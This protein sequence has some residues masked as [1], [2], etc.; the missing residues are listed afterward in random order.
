[1][2]PQAVQLHGKGGFGC[3]SLGQCVGRVGTG[4]IYQVELKG[5]GRKIL[6]A[7]AI[8]EQG[9]VGGLIAHHYQQADEGRRW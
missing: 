5:L 2:R 6:P 7:Q 1:M 9:Q 3:K 8:K 4:I